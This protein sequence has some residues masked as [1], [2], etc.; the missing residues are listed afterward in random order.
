MKRKTETQALRT[1]L[2]DLERRIADEV[3]ERVET[4]MQG[5]RIVGGD[6]RIFDGMTAEQMRAKVVALAMGVRFVDGASPDAIA[7]RFDHLVSTTTPDDPVRE[8]L[9]ARHRIT[10]N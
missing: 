3:S 4:A 6:G 9:M 7:A 8:T 10:V 2:T 1:R 5:Q